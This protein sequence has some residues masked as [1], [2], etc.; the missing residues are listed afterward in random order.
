MIL[1]AEKNEE[2]NN[3]GSADF[4]ELP[5]NLSEITQLPQGGQ[6]TMRKLVLTY[7]ALVAFSSVAFAGS[8]WE[9]TSQ[10]TCSH[11][12]STGGCSCTI[13]IDGCNPNGVCRNGRCS[14]SQKEEKSMVDFIEHH[15]DDPHLKIYVSSECKRGVEVIQHLKRQYARSGHQLDVK[16]DRPEATIV[17]SS[18]KSN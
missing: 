16:I 18:V 5:L 12:A 3:A 9:C 8:C 14:L 11:D 1:R 6:D 15:L 2:S 4:L 17:T 10:T 7:C 13:S